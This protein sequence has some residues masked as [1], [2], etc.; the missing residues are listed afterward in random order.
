[1]ARC[2][3]CGVDPGAILQ[4][5]PE[6]LCVPCQFVH[7]EEAGVARM[8]AEMDRE[9]AEFVAEMSRVFFVLAGVFAAGAVIAVAAVALAAALVAP[10]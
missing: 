2:P 10:G 7:A 8:M 9:C 5:S 3:L 6:R 4:A 1:M